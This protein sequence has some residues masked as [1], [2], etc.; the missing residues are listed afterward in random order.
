LSDIAELVLDQWVD[1]GVMVMPLPV[2]EILAA[3]DLRFVSAPLIA[4]MRYSIV[5]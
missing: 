2:R 5:G 3:H 1:V 4:L